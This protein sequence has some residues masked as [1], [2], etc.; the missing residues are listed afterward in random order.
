MRVMPRTVAAFSHAVAHQPTPDQMRALC[1]LG[2][3]LRW[4]AIVFASL[5]GVMATQAPH[6]LFEEIVAALAYN[7]LVM[8]AL[9]RAE[10]RFLPTIALV[11][12]VIDQLFCFVFIG[13]Y[14]VR[15]GNHQ[16]ASYVPAIIE[17]VAFFGIAGAVLSVALF[18]VCLVVAQTVFVVLWRGPL[19]GMG[20]FGAI[21][22]VVLL[23]A[24][25]AA[26]HEVLMS[27]ASE[28][29]DRVNPRAVEMALALPP[30]S[31]REQE[32]LRLLAHGCSNADIAA[33]L[34]LSGRTVK[35]CVER[36]LSQLR[37][38]NRAEAVAAASRLGL[39]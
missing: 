25:L 31:A 33:Q 36:L 15:P 21:M 16:V 6:L 3:A 26:V 19:D 12:T 5:A 9:R 30:L 18:T 1:R 29:Q 39:L 32:T 34:G 38:R 2:V 35:K 8:L 20:M 11:T 28:R 14:D 37:A 23:A 7:G 4:V 24:C 10:D 13:L 22:I 27:P 17:A